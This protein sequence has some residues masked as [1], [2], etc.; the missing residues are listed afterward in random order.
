MSCCRPL[1]LIFPRPVRLW[2]I[3]PLP[4]PACQMFRGRIFDIGVAYKAFLPWF[5]V[6]YVAM[7]RDLPE[8]VGWE[9]LG[10]V[11]LQ[12]SEQCIL[13]G[14]GVVSLLANGAYPGRHLE[15]LLIPPRAVRLHVGEP[16]VKRGKLRKGLC[17][18]FREAYVGFEV[19]VHVPPMMILAHV[20]TTEK[21]E[22][23]TTYHHLRGSRPSSSNGSE[24][25]S[26]LTFDISCSASVS[27]PE[28]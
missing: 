13:V 2:M 18:G 24:H 8:R 20:V 15:R 1:S 11:L 25:H 9:N 5:C 28:S 16:V 7:P 6:D 21:G 14:I 3:L 10:M 17:A 22:L 12:V 4:L 19:T 27:F 23:A 26:Q